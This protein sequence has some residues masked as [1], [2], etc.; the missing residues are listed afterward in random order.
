MSTDTRARGLTGL[1]TY[2]YENC[3][4]CFNALKNKRTTVFFKC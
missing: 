1:C 4:I 2:N 3:P